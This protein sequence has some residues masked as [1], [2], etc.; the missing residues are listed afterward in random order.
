M[1][2]QRQRGWSM[3]LA[4]HGAIVLGAGVAGL[5]TAL[6]LQRAGCRGGG[7]R[8]AA[9]GG[10]CV[11]RQ[12]RAAQPRHRG[13]DRAARHAAQ[14]ARLADRPARPAVGAAQLFPA[15]AALA[16]A[17]DRGR[18]AASRDGD[19]RRDARAAPR[20]VDLL[21]GA[22]GAGAVSRA[23]P[24]GRDRCRCGKAMPTAPVRWWSA[25]CA[26][27][28][29]SAPRNSTPTICARCFPASRAR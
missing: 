9:A 28:T 1:A 8:S 2:P 10:R 19:L 6:Y 20:D 25:R 29:A 24:P 14:G 11:V 13:A 16:A 12:C 18:A 4:R 21:A 17:L 22:V 7:D 27:G 3:T 5:S 15:R 26:S 23:D